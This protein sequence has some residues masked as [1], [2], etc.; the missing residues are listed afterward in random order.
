M[1]AVLLNTMLSGMFSSVHVINSEPAAA[2]NLETVGPRD[3]CAV[4]EQHHD[5]QSCDKF[6]RNRAQTDRKRPRCQFIPQN[7]SPEYG[8]TEL[9]NHTIFSHCI[10]TVWDYL[11]SNPYLYELRDHHTPMYLSA[12][13][14]NLR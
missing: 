13:Y 3:T 14:Q 1:Y 5:I 9:Q 8:K 12:M 2:I 7:K 11:L 6:A 4:C 10:P